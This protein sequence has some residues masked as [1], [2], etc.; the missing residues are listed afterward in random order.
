MLIGA[1]KCNFCNA[2]CSRVPED[3]GKYPFMCRV[4]IMGNT[5]YLCEHCHKHANDRI[6]KFLKGK[7]HDLPTTGEEITWVPC[8][9]PARDRDKRER[10]TRI[11]EMVKH[12]LSAK[13]YYDSDPKVV[14]EAISLIDV[15]DER[16]K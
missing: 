6:I 2:Y 14:D 5:F 4:E 11:E 1:T 13:S 9:D 3:K 12:L 16:T 7:E 15:I 10:R 8:D